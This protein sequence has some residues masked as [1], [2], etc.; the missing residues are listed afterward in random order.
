MVNVSNGAVGIGNGE[1][2]GVFVIS[3][4][5][6]RDLG[7]VLETGTSN[8]ICVS[9]LIWS[10]CIPRFHQD[11]G[12]RNAVVSENGSLDN[13]DIAWIAQ[14]VL[15][16]QTIGR[17]GSRDVERAFLVGRSRIRWAGLGPY[18]QRRKKQE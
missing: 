18:C 4:F 7:S 15:G 5:V 17:G 14:L 12:H 3:T 9:I 10:T 6:C 11:F 8:R 2:T 13:Q 1:S 16:G